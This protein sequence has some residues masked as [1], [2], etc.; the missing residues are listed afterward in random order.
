MSNLTTI[1]AKSPKSG[2][3]ATVNFDFGETVEEAVEKFGADVVLSGFIRTST[4]TA[5]AAIRRYLE[6]G[7]EQE[8]IEEKMTDW[9]PGVTIQRVV[10]PV[11]AILRKAD[12][13]EGDEL[14]ALIAKL[15]GKSKG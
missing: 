12:D 7:L 1:A 11:A 3:S 14:E 5:Q 10:D 6:V 4:I 2:T 8:A 15:Q 13:M 9:K